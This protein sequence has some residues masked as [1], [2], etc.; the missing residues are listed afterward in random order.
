MHIIQ[1]ILNKKKQLPEEVSKAAERLEKIYEESI[2]KLSQEKQSLLIWK[3]YYG[4]SLDE[5]N[6][7][8]FLVKGSHS[9]VNGELINSIRAKIEESK[10]FQQLTEEWVDET[11]K[12]R[13]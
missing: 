11:W 13:E 6:F 4:L 10:N 2:A 8:N 9:K 7:I 3:Q 1:R 12:L 5:A